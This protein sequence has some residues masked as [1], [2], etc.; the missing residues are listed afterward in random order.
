MH[1]CIQVQHSP[2]STQVR[3]YATRRLGY[4]GEEV[5]TFERYLYNILAS[6]GSGEFA[7]KHILEPFGWPREALEGRLE[8]LGSTPVTF[9]YGQHDWM[10]PKHGVR[11]CKQLGK[12]R[13]PLNGTCVADK[14]V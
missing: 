13:A 1:V 14:T 7:L 3:N 9:V 8:A 2:L 5:I 10:D 6:D 11:V 12:L 4:G